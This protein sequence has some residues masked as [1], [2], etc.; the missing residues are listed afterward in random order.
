MREEE[1]AGMKRY[2]DRPDVLE[3][4]IN[5]QLSLLRWRSLSRASRDKAIGKT[6]MMMMMKGHLTSPTSHMWALAG[7]PKFSNI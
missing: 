2:Q 3:I 7:E 6:T 1:K 5:N 4:L